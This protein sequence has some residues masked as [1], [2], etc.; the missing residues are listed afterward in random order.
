MHGLAQ[1]LDRLDAA[2]Q[3]LDVTPVGVGAYHHI[4]EHQPIDVDEGFTRLPAVAEHV[5][6]GS[7]VIDVTVVLVG[8]D[9]AL[10]ASWIFVRGFRS[11]GRDWDTTV[12]RTLLNFITRWHLTNEISI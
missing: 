4:A 2:G 7:H 10:V 8:D 9:E 3:V 11:I 5:G 12:L 6:Y 1:H